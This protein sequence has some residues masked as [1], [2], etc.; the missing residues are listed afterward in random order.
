[1]WRWWWPRRQGRARAELGGCVHD[2]RDALAHPHEVAEAGHGVCVC[3]RFYWGG[4]GTNGQYHGWMDGCSMILAPYIY[5]I[6]VVYELASGRY[7]SPPQHTNAHWLRDQLRYRFPIPQQL[8][9]CAGAHLLD[10]VSQTL[11]CE[12]DMLVLDELHHKVAVGKRQLTQD[13]PSPCRA[14]RSAPGTALSTCRC[15]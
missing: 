8:L 13:E 12:V 10:R 3:V 5:Y 1:M 7:G 15:Q 4:Q 2:P 6:T 9:P 11:A 14:A